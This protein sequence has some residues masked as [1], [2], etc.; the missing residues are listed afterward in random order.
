MDSP[1]KGGPV[2]Q[3]VFSSQDIIME[4][5]SQTRPSNVPWESI[6][7]FHVGGP[8]AYSK[9]AYLSGMLHIVKGIT[10]ESVT[11]CLG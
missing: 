8:H 9:Y 7:S 1:H 10:P 3:K 5:L 11:T 6:I 2:I 4:K